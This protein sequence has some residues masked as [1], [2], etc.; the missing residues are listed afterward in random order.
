M[1]VFKTVL[2]RGADRAALRIHPLRS[3]FNRR[4][5][6]VPRILA[7]SRGGDDDEEVDDEEDEETL[8]PSVDCFPSLR[9]SPHPNNQ[10][11]QKYFSDVSTQ[12]LAAVTKSLL[13]KYS[14]QNQVLLA[15]H[16]DPGSTAYVTAAIQEAA[17]KLD[18]NVVILSYQRLMNGFRQ[19]NA[20]YKGF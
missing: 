3:S 12:H 10:V 13:S 11:Y 15:S 14:V 1:Q 6:S 20:H 2:S 9:L 8:P 19:Y 18:M 5:R 7:S 17:S 16:P 4:R